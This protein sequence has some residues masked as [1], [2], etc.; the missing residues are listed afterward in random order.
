M[1][2]R[3][4]T[5]GQL[6]IVAARVLPKQERGG[7]RKSAK[8]KSTLETKLDFP[9]VNATDLS[10]ARVITEHAPLLA[11]AVLGG[12]KKFATAF[13]DAQ[14]MLSERTPLGPATGELRSTERDPANF[15]GN[16]RGQ[17]GKRGRR[18]NLYASVQRFNGAGSP[19]AL[20]LLGLAAVPGPP[21]HFELE[22]GLSGLDGV[23]AV[24]DPRAALFGKSS[25]ARPSIE[26]QG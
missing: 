10:Q 24:L 21:R 15:R 4:L 2:R 26:V 11:D 5:K 23:G 3:H 14:K 12:N 19:P 6:A 22:P 25:H 9:L 17:S 1:A 13:A 16:R 20:T 18:R 8:A 7:D